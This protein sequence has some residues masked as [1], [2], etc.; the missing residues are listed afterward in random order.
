VD[1]D[2]AMGALELIEVD[3]EVL[4]AVFDAEEANRP[5]APQ[6]HD[7]VE[8]NLCYPIFLNHGNVEKD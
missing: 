7:H 5:E 2:T 6:I 8:R 4:P 3:Y 1:E